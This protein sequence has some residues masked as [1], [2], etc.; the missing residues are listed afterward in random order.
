[1]D[2]HILQGNTKFYS[3]TQTDIRFF[4]R[5]YKFLKVLPQRAFAFPTRKYEIKLSSI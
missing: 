5:K 2:I 4:T 1:M 3:C